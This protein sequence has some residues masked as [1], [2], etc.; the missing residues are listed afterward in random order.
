MPQ[1]GDVFPSR[2]AA[3]IAASYVW[4][5]RGY[6]TVNSQGPSHSHVARYIFGC[7]L[8]VPVKRPDAC[9]RRSTSNPWWR[10]SGTDRGACIRVTRS[11]TIILRTVWGYGDLR[12]RVLRVPRASG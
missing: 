6:R 12:G 5:S 1:V 10:T 11:T 8:H 7:T 4:H 2:R 3:L 9:P